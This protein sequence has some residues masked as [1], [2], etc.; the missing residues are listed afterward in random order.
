MRRVPLPTVGSGLLLALLAIAVAYGLQRIGWAERIDLVAFDATTPWIAAAA[1]GRVVVVEIDQQSLERLGRWPWPRE[2][3]AT[4]IDRLAAARPAVIGYDVLFAEPAAGDWAG[5]DALVAAVERAGNIVLPIIAEPPARGL[6]PLEILPFGELP[7]VAAALGHGHLAADPDGRLRRLHLRAGVG[8]AYWPAFAQAIREVVEPAT[9]ADSA[10][11]R[12]SPTADGFLDWVVGD[13]LL[14]PI[15]AASQR[16]RHYSAADV[17]RRRELAELREAIVL[18]GA[19]AYGL[20]ARV[21]IGPQHRSALAPPLYFNAFAVEALLAER[22]L[23]AVRS[24]GP[25]AALLAAAAFLP[26]LAVRHAT[27]RAQLAML[28]LAPIVPIAIGIAALASGQVLLPFAS[29]ALTVVGVLAAALV[30]DAVGRLRQARLERSLAHTALTNVADAV[31]TTD[32]AKVIDY[33]N[34]AAERLFA[35]DDSGLAGRHLDSFAPEIADLVERS[36]QRPTAGRP[37]LGDRPLVIGLADATDTARPNEWRT[38]ALGA[39]G[40]GG[41]I[42]KAAVRRLGRSR[43]S[44]WVIALNDVTDEQRLLDEVAFRATHDG[45]TKLPNRHLLIDRLGSAIE[46][47]RRRERLVVVAFLDVDRLKSINDALGHAVG[48]AV[49]VELA[50]RLASLGRA[51]DTV[52]RIGGDEF[53]LLLEDLGTKGEVEAAIARYR[54]ALLEPVTVDRQ[55][56]VIKASVGVACF[57]HDGETPDEL[58]RRA[59]T[60]MYRAKSGGRDQIVFFD[61]A[62]HGDESGGLLLDAALRRGIE[63]DELELHYQPRI[64]LVQ[65]RPAGVESLVRWHHPEQG[66]LPPGRFIGLAEETGSIVQLGRW[67]VE[68][69]CADLACAALRDTGLRL[70]IN[71]SVVQ[72]KRDQSFVDFVRRTLQRHRLAPDRLELEVTESLFL[73]PSLPM[74]GRRLGELA[75]LGVHLSIDDFGTGY[76]SLAYINRFPFDRIKIDRSF[77]HA[78]GQD[79]SSQAIIR[80]IVGLSEALA[81]KTT[82]EGVEEEGQLAFLDELNCNEAQGYFFGRPVPLGDLLDSLSA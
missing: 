38:V 53:V 67:V 21:A 18:V 75:R 29:V 70:S 62:L 82:A 51:T 11:D 72:L 28:G 22:T 16:L 81:K 17:L 35:V 39:A 45:L 56:F 23:T 30:I 64:D 57:P 6:P 50:S 2:L 33:A 79:K 4:L 80:A 68:R 77:V 69:A 73:D 25:I 46:R 9:T 47:G 26:W 27:H 31:L 52:A 65:R 36:D 76:S 15:P 7:R 37:A 34:P 78:V 5:D 8:D 74:L 61:A 32:T 19:T 14:V 55:R 58:L 44:G 41:R 43:Q 10:G 42:V 48:D 60:A 54:R 66:F 63:R 20:T 3:H 12:A 1:S 71:V 13:E 49:L 59:D 24:P 40:T